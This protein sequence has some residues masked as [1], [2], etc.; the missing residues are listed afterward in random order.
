M[1]TDLVLRPM[2][3][4]PTLTKARIAG[5]LLAISTETGLR[6]LLAPTATAIHVRA[7]LRDDDE[8]GASV[9]VHFASNGSKVTGTTRG[10]GGALLSYCFGAIAIELGCELFDPQ[11]GATIRA[12]GDER[13]LDAAKQVVADHEESVLADRSYDGG[14]G[15]GEGDA[16]DG[17][18]ARFLAQ[19]AADEKVLLSPGKSDELEEL[20]A[21][22]DDPEQLYERLLDSPAVEEVFLGEREFLGAF[23]RFRLSGG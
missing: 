1:S 23:R 21:L 19:L 4:G 5:A 17:E 20:E 10:A 13:L 9:S 8:L 16:R 6:F 18:V 14:E 12:G 7:R 22:A 15:A 3:G 11:E 2:P